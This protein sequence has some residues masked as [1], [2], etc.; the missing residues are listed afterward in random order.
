M[1]IFCGLYNLIFMLSRAIKSYSCQ[2]YLKVVNTL[3]FMTKNDQKS[4]ASHSMF[5][6][7]F[8]T[9]FVKGIHFL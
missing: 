7:Y 3:K 5:L 4:N 2:V 9:I 6:P 1:I 8:I